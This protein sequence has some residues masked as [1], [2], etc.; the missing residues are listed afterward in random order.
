MKNKKPECPE[1]GSKNILTSVNG[2]RRCRVCGHKWETKVIK[3]VK[4]REA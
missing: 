2:L 4:R 3:W 1:C